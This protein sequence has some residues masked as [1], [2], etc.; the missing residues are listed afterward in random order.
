MIEH[1]GGRCSACGTTEQLEIDHIDWRTKNFAVSLMWPKS[2]REELIEELGKCQLLCYLHHLEKS[3]EDWRE[4]R[5]EIGFTHGTRYGW[6]KK[7]CPCDAC[8][9]KKREYYDERNAARRK[10]P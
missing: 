5:A 3:I 2:R 7:K 9:S 6:L 10:R 4:Q 8:Q 1:L